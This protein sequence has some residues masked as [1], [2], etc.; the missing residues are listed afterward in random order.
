M[1]PQSA[2]LAYRE[3]MPAPS[4]PPGAFGVE[5]TRERPESP[6]RSYG[7]PRRGGTF[8]AWDHVIGRL[9]S[10]EAYWLTTVTPGGRPHAV[11]IWGVMVGDDLYLETGAPETRKNRNLEG[12]R[13]ILVHLDGV[14]DAV[15]VRGEAVMIVPPRELGSA[16]AAAFHT[17]YSGYDPEPGGWD[18]G[19]LI[20][21]APSTLLA[22][23]DMPTATRWRWVSGERSSP[24]TARRRPRRAPPATG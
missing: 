9:R 6:P 8:V 2:G 19:G 1:P 12:N 4:E 24:S 18:G 14:N 3:P 7:V 17:K 5:P 10:A 11:P 16:L 13:H 22:W 21:V 15:I 20:R 23:G